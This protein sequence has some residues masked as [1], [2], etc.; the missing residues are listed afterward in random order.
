M[1][2][3]KLLDGSVVSAIVEKVFPDET[4][5]CRDDKKRPKESLYWVIPGKKGEP[6]WILPDDPT[7]T[8]GFLGQWRPYEFLSRAKWKL[9]MI[10]Y[11]G[12]RLG[13]VP[14]VVPLH[15]I[16][17]EEK[18]WDHLGWALA[19]PPVLVIYVGTPSPHRK[20][21]LCLVD[22]ANGRVLSIGKVPLG[23]VAGVA[24]NR[25]AD[26][27]EKLA[28]E[29][30]GRAPGTYFLDRKNGITTQEFIAGS[31]TSGR[32]TESHLDCLLDL[33][34]PD[35]TMSLH[36]EVETSENKIRALGNIAPKDREV[37]MK[38]LGKADDPAPLPAVWEHGD[39][40]PWNLKRAQDGSLKA[41]D[42]EE[43]SRSGLPL[44]DL[45]Y[46]HLIQALELGEKDIFPGVFVEFL[47][48]Y[49]D[50]L[51]IAREMAGKIVRAAIVRYWLRFH[52]AGDGARADFFIHRLNGLPGSLS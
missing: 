2:R 33:A 50:H 4:E 47:N 9:L 14:G 1:S 19:Q 44:F 8:F 17:P 51:G 40:A 48:R 13:C 34:I 16:V 42:W 20:A 12:K 41:I 29:K 35:E 23:P 15:I 31:P 6:R 52:E 25:E 38:A 18:N 27:L 10:A 21:I 28:K 7:N 46:F 45:V 39:F 5:T 49:L 3:R 22:S 43:A 30:P 26:N 24:I 32:L 36:Q 11:R 37:L